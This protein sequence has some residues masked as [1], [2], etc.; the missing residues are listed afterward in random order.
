MINDILIKNFRGIK[1]LEIKDMRPITLF[2][3]KNNVGKS[4]L[5]EALFLFFDHFSPDV[6]MKLNNFR[7]NIC[8]TTTVNI[9]E[10]L[11]YELDA[12]N[13][14]NISVSYDNEE[15]LLEF[16]R[17][18]S[19]IPV[20][21][22][23]AAQE[24]INQFVSYAK[25]AYSL[26]FDYKQ[27]DYEEK[28][29]FAVSSAGVMRNNNTT[30][31]DNQ[32]QNMPYMMFINALLIEQDNAVVEW[33]GNLEYQ[34]KK[35][36]VI[37]VLKMIE[38]DIEDIVTLA[39]NGIVQLYVKI[40]NKLIPLKLTGDGMY[41]LLYIVLSIIKNPHSIILIDEIETGFHYS[42]YSKFWE[43]IAN[44]ARDCDC[45]IVATTHSYECIVGAVEGMKMA[46][47]E[48]DFCYYRLERNG[49]GNNAYRYATELLESAITT[50]M[51]VR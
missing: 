35:Q 29:H 9:W 38:P 19:Y 20:N 45:Q 17:D 37:D 3:G 5:L 32:V 10:S 28:G 43:V 2:S 13:L 11:F 26:K 51:E 24:I 14:L 6:F 33:F 25:E 4:S 34:G 16:A 31:P 21:D 50:D 12:D 42:L 48:E 39:L 47:R 7:R 46:Q 36:Q 40:Q 22:I 49:T 1:E 27:G 23:N 15:A 44:V 41:K 18:D 30:L 8:N